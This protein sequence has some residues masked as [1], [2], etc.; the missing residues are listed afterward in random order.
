[1]VY[2]FAARVPNK[3][4]KSNFRHYMPTGLNNSTTHLIM[5]SSALSMG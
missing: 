2:G 5:L 1:M 3:D 4:R